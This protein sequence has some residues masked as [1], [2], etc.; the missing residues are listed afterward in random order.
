MSIEQRT[1]ALAAGNQT[2]F[3]S[4]Q[5]TTGQ[6]PPMIGLQ[7]QFQVPNGGFR[8]PPMPTPVQNLIN[9]QQRDRAAEGRQGAQDSAAVPNIT[10]ITQPGS[11]RASPNLFRPDHSTTHTREGVGPNGERWQITVNET[12]TTIPVQQ[13]AP[14]P[15]PHHHHHHHQGFQGSNPILDNLQAILRNADRGVLNP[16]PTPASTP[17]VTGTIQAMPSSL[18]NPAATGQN[19][20][21]S[22]PL[23][24]ANHSSTPPSLVPNQPPSVPIANTAVQPT[25]ATNPTN[26]VEPM[27]YILSSP[28]GPRALLMSNSDTFY[29][30]R[31]WSM[32]RRRETP[33]TGQGGADGQAAGRL[34]AL[35]EFL[36][37]DRNPDRR[38]VRQDRF[39]N[40]QAQRPDHPV[41]VVVGHANA[42][43]GA[44]ALAAQIGP[45]IWLFVRLA[46]FVW[47]FTAGNHS[48][49]RFFMVSALAFGIFIVNTGLL[50]GVFEQLWGPIRRHV[51]TLI[52]LAGPDAAL[53]PA[54]NA[55]IPQ[56]P[57]AAA[58]P[59]EPRRGRRR[60][61]GELDEAEVAA[62]LIERHRQ[63]NAGWLRVH[64]RRA[65]HAALLFL[66]SLV[67]GV[68][69]RHIAA[70][71][72]EANAAEA[73]RQRLIDEAA[74]AENA[75]AAN[76]QTSEGDVTGEP[77]EPHP[78]EPESAAPPP[79]IEV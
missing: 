48:W 75:E 69:E 49:L 14:H 17:P 9:Q 21:L 8:T 34:P 15:H 28:Q 71:E 73:E 52:P 56:Q 11:G 39:G 66:A 20:S 51:E 59:A 55:R 47:F 24:T 72:A 22:G 23:P 2:L 18:P 19:Q 41:E 67:P 35:G 12:T 44:G 36:R 65:E 26:N 64:I 32:R 62:R 27:V 13:G 3:T 45:L 42:N 31:Q 30:P 10:R 74:A 4:Q 16:Q 76:E 79:V 43:Q 78:Q 77:Q 60:R 6:T 61:P 7:N 38:R 63:A 25:F 53:V 29:T 37:N 5:P 40:A 46:G 33:A 57:E 1:R 54:A 70:R 50:N 58:A 68:G